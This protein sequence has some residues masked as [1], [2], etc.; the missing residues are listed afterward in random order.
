MLLGGEGAV[1]TINGE[2]CEEMVFFGVYM[3]PFGK[4]FWGRVP[5]ISHK[6][7]DAREKSIFQ[8]VCVAILGH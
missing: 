5:D 8:G 7:K 6:N 3:L 4:H 1:S 2:D